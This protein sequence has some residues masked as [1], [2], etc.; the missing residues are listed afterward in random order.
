MELPAEAA[1]QVVACPHCGSE[2]EVPPPENEP[3]PEEEI[4]SIRIK[5]LALER[6]AVIRARSYCLIA[7]GGCAVGAAQFIYFAVNQMRSGGGK[8]TGYVV[9]AVIFAALMMFFI[10]KAR[11]A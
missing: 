10:G 8:A 3:T 1:G 9:C 11:E 4:D 2:F 7:A 6:R 5:R